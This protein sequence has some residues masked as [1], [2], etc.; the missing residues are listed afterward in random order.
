M[1]H[2][3]IFGSQILNGRITINEERNQEESRCQEGSCKKEEVALPASTGALAVNRKA[4]ATGPF[5]LP[6]GRVRRI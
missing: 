5:F 1:N 6:V 2:T 4:P 3:A